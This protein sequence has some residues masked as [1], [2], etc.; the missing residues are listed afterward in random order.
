MRLWVKIRYQWHMF[1]IHWILRWYKILEF[2]NNNTY[3]F[4]KLYKSDNLSLKIEIIYEYILTKVVVII[5]V[6]NET[7]K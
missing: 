2:Y 1:K 6:W 3:N 7:F 5:M 4:R